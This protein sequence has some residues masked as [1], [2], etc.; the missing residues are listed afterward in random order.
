VTREGT[1]T[2]KPRQYDDHCLDC[3]AMLMP[4]I[5]AGTCQIGHERYH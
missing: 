2:D 5:E 4:E 1:V 3:L